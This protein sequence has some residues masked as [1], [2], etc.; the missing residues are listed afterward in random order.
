M[1]I[2]SNLGKTKQKTI[3]KVKAI[4]PRS[5]CIWR[6]FVWFGVLPIVSTG[7]RRS[8]W[9]SYWGNWHWWCQPSEIQRAKQ[10]SQRARGR[11]HTHTRTL[12]VSLRTGLQTPP[13][14]PTPPLLPHTQRGGSHYR[15]LLRQ[16]E[17]LLLTALF[18]LFIPSSFISVTSVLLSSLLIYLSSRSG[19]LCLLSHFMSLV[20][21]RAICYYL[22]PFLSPGFLPPH[23]N[24]GRV[25]F[26]KKVSSKCKDS[27][28]PCQ[29]KSV[30]LWCHKEAP[31]LGMTTCLSTLCK[32]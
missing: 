12:S 2:K 25:H 13:A 27:A 5:V 16:C 8:R 14:P 22:S 10:T 9:C 6:R 30:P 19:T 3:V 24:T 1:G 28:C 17:H 15:K 29:T 18:F 20:S 4:C 11:T 7:R 23:R 26:P 31:T 32:S 21:R